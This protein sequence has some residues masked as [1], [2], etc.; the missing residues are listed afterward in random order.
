MRRFVLPDLE[1]EIAGGGRVLRGPA[2]L[3]LLF[4]HVGYFCL[5]LTLEGLTGPHA[6][7]DPSV[8]HLLHA[9]EHED[10]S[11]LV[12]RG[13]IDG[14][15]IALTGNVRRVFDWFGAYVHEVLS[16]RTPDLRDL[17]TWSAGPEA[18]LHRRETYVRRRELSIVYPSTFGSHAELCWADPADI[19]GRPAEWGPALIA[20]VRDGERHAYD[21]DEASDTRWWLLSEFQTVLIRGGATG[22]HPDI[23]ALDVDRL[24][25]VEYLALRRGALSGIQ[26]QTQ[27]AAAERRPVARREVADWTWFLGAVTDDYVI[28]GW[29]A[30]LLEQIKRLLR[31]SSSLR[32][33]FELEDQVRRNVEVFQSRLDAESD[34]TGLMLAVFF[35]IVAAT[36]LLPLAQAV[37]SNVSGVSL[38]DFGSFP[39]THYTAFLL[40]SALL[41]VVVGGVAVTLLVRNRY[42]RPP[43]SGRRRPRLTRRRAER[44]IP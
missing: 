5:R 34:R 24:Q 44:R 17:D 19:P 4:W 15:D 37:Y 42:L 43:Q 12:V 23:R 3:S 41:L 18:G 40:L 7:V 22:L 20:E 13:A 16:G 32:D 39:V 29:S 8:V 38:T 35:G 10:A 14:H 30:S 11:T 2:T 27:L 21:I 31:N 28:G 9:A 25:M 1:I 36:S 26:R 6:Q 33:V